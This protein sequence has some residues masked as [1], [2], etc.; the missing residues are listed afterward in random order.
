MLR[1]TLLLAALLLATTLPAQTLEEG[2]RDPPVSA[3]PKTYWAFVNGN[4]NLRAMTRELED[5]RA[6]G[7]GGVD[8]WDVAG[9]VDPR[10]EIPTGPP[11]MGPQSVQMIAHGIREGKRL[12]LEMGLV[13]SSSW[14][15]GGSWVAAEDGV[16][17]L[18]R[19]DTVVEGGRRFAEALPFPAIPTDYRAGK[20]M[21]LERDARG[22]PT[23]FREVAVLAYPAAGPRPLDT[24][25]LR[26]LDAF[27]DG[28]R[29]HWDV[30]PGR[31]RITRYVMTG[32]GQPLM[33]PSPN[34]NGRM[35]D[36]FSQDAQRHHLQ[37]FF[38]RLEAELGDL[39]EAGLDYLYNDSYEANSSNWTPGLTATFRERMG[40]DPR[41]YLPALHG[42]TVVDA[43][44][45]E[46][47]LF[48]FN[49]V[50]SDLIIDNHYV[51]GRQLCAEKGLGYYAEAGGPGPP[52]HN[53]PFESL[54]ALGSLTVPRGEFW[55]DTLKQADFLNTLQIV[56][57]PASAAHLYDQPAV[58]AEA[59]TGTL[60]WQ[61]GPGD[62]KAT[63]DRALCDGLNRFVY[64]TSPHTPP[65]AG[66][67]GW[68]YNF[69]TLMNTTRIWWPLSDNF[70]AY[71]GRS[72]FLLQQGDFVGD[73]LY[74]YGDQAPNFVDP[75]AV[76]AELGP[77]Y[78]Y[79]FVNS[80]VIL[81]RLTVEDGD[82][83]LTHGPRYRVLVLP[84][85]EAV[86]P[87]VLARIKAFVSAGGTVLGDA[88]SRAHSLRDAARND[89]L[90]REIAGRLWTEGKTEKAYGKGRVFTHAHTIGEVLQSLG[91][92]PDITTNLPDP[93]AIDFIHRRTP[94]GDLYFLRNTT[95]RAISFDCT[96]RT[97]RGIPE[98]WDAVTGT[99]YAPP[100][101]RR[102]GEQ[103]TLPL[104]LPPSG[105]LF[106]VFREGVETNPVTTLARDGRQVFP[107][108]TAELGLRLDTRGERVWTRP[109]NYVLTHAD[110]K[111]ET[112]VVPP[113]PP[114][115]DLS[116]PWEVRFAHGQGAPQ[117]TVFDTLLSWADHPD[118]NIRYYSGIAT[119]HH[120]FELAAAHSPEDYVIEL[121][122]GEVAHVAEVYLNGRRLDALW[123]APYAI[124][125][126]AAARVGTN[127][128]TV[129]VANTWRNRLVGDARRGLGARGAN[130]N[131]TKGP[132]AWS[133]PLAEYSVGPGGILGPVIVRFGGR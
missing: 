59:F 27:F 101:Y 2:F 91:A 52:F 110:G 1:K 82:F 98:F 13:A 72:C 100:A 112:Q 49:R 18:F 124:D 70:H 132:N 60:L 113:L 39:S 86:D 84:P 7:L 88:P 125:L 126:S 109:G 51:Y 73:V 45:T 83:V 63:A 6:R 114:T 61:V 92:V 55:Y 48:D 106:V 90:V 11:F 116:G 87:A 33:R 130:T 41:P 8:I 35:I 3:R 76:E 77:G 94:E 99:V 21:L 50:L 78:D 32:T 47:F 67:P 121:D 75:L 9:W 40:Y 53:V 57:G 122:L 133:V 22:L 46:R 30:P 44:T 25:Q 127:Y 95:D 131:I 105:S 81:N 5:Y 26:Q 38:D 64:H 54:R 102:S 104:T 43:L 23:F 107:G 115:Q 24:L 129:E 68:V 118:E 16:M 19:S 119:Y 31:W 36:H 128:L 12:G 34:A 71:L 58:E 65:E 96:L 66:N 62:L 93:T 117:R 4:Y 79:D 120:A 69:G 111:R 14:N 56:K 37:F 97:G 108:T 17:G 80:D 89:A 28:E 10:G 74:Y 15:S 42:D 85:G 29:L 123:G 20:P 103:T